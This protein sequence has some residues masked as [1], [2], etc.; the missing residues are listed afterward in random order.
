VAFLIFARMWIAFSAG[1][2][3]GTAAQ[4]EPERIEGKGVV[5]LHSLARRSL[6]VDFLNA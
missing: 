3:G 2:L 4:E 1:T 5:I 6:A